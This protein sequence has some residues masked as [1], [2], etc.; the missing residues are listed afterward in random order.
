MVLRSTALAIVLVALMAG[1]AVA[2]TVSVS[3]TS[4]PASKYEPGLTYETVS[5]VAAPGEGNELYVTLDAGVLTVSD[6]AGVQAGPGCEPA[7]I[8]QARCPIPHGLA[9][10][11]VSLGDENDRFTTTLSASV[12]GG[13]GD[14]TLQAQRLD[15]G[16][17]DDVL[18]G[19]EVEGGPGADTITAPTV[20]YR[21]ATTPVRVDLADL[22]VVGQPGEGDRIDPIVENVVGGRFADVLVGDG[23]ANRLDGGAGDDRIDG[24]GGGDAIF[25]GAG[26]DRLLG[27]DG[28]DEVLGAGG[29]DRVDGGRG[30]DWV[31]G[32]GGADTVLGGAGRDHVDGGAGADRV[33]GGPGPDSVDGGGGGPDRVFSRDGERDLVR[34][35]L[36]RPVDAT[37]VAQADTYDLVHACGAV[38]RPRPTRPQILAVTQGRELI[39]AVR[40]DVGCSQ[41]QPR[42]CR[43]AV[44]LVIAGRVVA[45]RVIRVAPGEG[46]EPEVTVPRAAYRA[47][48]RNCGRLSVT[49]LITARDAAG[50]SFTLRR[51]V[52]LRSATARCGP[53]DPDRSLLTTGAW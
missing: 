44:R 6:L 45:R 38:R 41:D 14:D 22:T 25:G 17:G 24:R 4:T 43:L 39:G 27:G 7:S 21:S 11:T 1:S 36:T 42:G 12:A 18:R 50:R 16:P 53:P 37:S 10:L 9:D 35:T 30:A 34:C 5:Y 26:V 19:Q 32:D 8:R 23:R 47:A 49:A 40:I 29:S 52:S 31:T 2:G 51:S 28:S 46:F 48:S 13:G 20:T 15:G 3:S 33:G